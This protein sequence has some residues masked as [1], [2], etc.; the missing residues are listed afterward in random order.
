MNVL[1]PVLV[2][3]FAGMGAAWHRLCRYERGGGHQPCSS[4]SCTW[5][6]IWRWALPFPPMCWPVRCPPT[7]TIKIEPGY[8]KRPD[9]DGQRACL[10]GGGQLGG[11]QDAL[12]HHGRLLGVHDLPAGHQVYPAPGHDHQGSHAGRQRQKAGC[13][14]A[15]VRHAHRLHLRIHRCGRRHDDAAHPHQRAGL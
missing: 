8:Q 10:H 7:P 9:H 2:T 1:F 3:F 6:P 13:P 12:R 14:V 15:G 5:T 11:Q 4:P